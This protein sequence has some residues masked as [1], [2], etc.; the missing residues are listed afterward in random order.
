MS[1]GLSSWNKGPKRFNMHQLSDYDRQSKNRPLLQEKEKIAQLI[2]D[3]EFRKT[4]LRQEGLEAHFG[5]LKTLFRQGL[6]IRRQ[7][8]KEGNVYQLDK[9]KSQYVP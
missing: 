9:D 6:A 8:D 2:N 3:E 4:R 7:D 1:K 5:T